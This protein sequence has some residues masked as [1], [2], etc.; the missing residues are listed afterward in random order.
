MLWSDVYR[1]KLEYTEN[2]TY[3]SYLR[4]TRRANGWHVLEV[5]ATRALCVVGWPWGSA[6]WVCWTDRRY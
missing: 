4:Q 1:K 5:R 6:A 2:Y 3:W